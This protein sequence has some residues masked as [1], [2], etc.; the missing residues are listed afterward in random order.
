MKLYVSV[1]MEGITG[2]PDYT[3][4]DSGKHNYERARKIMTEET[5]Y[6]IDAAFKF[7]C[8]DVLINDSHSKMNNILIDQ[9]HPDAK[10][11]TG[12]VKALSMMQGIDNTYGGAMFVG[13][14]ARAG[15]FGVMS[16]AMI[17][18]VRNFYINEQP[19]GEMGIN[20][21]VAGH[22]GVPLL[23][24]AGDDQAAKE[25]EELIPNVTT[26]AVKETISRSAV[27]SL[28]PKKAGELLTEKVKHAL[29]NRENVKPL[30]LP[31]NP[32]IKIEFNNYGQ[33]EWANLMPGT[34][35]EPGTTIVKYQA[36]NIIEAYQAMLVMTELAMRTAFS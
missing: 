16:H 27:K 5:N 22:F 10:L 19:V 9:L 28:T 33:A 36:K 8:E 26:V 18:A 32:E 6:V 3:Y 20:A 31:E 25:A 17:H 7:G 13:Y 29:E 21:Y 11:I 34:E 24:V 35:I 23:L 4:V 14:H 30:I 1:D 2:L 15:Q 12:E